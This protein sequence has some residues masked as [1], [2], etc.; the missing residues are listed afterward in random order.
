MPALPGQHDHLAH[1][2]GRAR[3]RD[4]HV[5]LPELRRGVV[6]NRKHRRSV[7]VILKGGRGI[8]A[9][10]VVDAGLLLP[11]AT[12]RTAA[13]RSGRAAGG[14]GR[15]AALHAARG[16]G[17]P[18]R[19][20]GLTRRLRIGVGAAGPT[21]CRARGRRRPRRRGAAHVHA[22]AGGHAD[23]DR[24]AGAAPVHDRGGRLV[25][26]IAP[27]FLALDDDAARLA[28]DV[29]PRLLALDGDGARLAVDG[30]PRALAPD[31]H[32]VGSADP[33]TH[34]EARG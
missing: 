19:T 22:G 8:T 28:V 5:S 17:G 27:H 13:R 21:R 4:A 14:A 31:R 9:P 15:A 32:V 12:R 18:L 10:A 30:A 1:R 24:D 11:A 29:A 3:P 25:I 34:A 23:T 16:T 6:A 20:T 7:I 2:A 33:R 26:G